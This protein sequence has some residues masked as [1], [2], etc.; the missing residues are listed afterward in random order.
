MRKTIELKF[1]KSQMKLIDLV[2]LNESKHTDEEQSNKN[3]LEYSCQKQIW[4]WLDYVCDNQSTGNPRS[5]EYV[6]EYHEN[7]VIEI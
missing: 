6:Q 1:Y 5:K 7:A 4:V 2:N 3:H